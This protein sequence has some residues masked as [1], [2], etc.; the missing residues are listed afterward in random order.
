MST[1]YDLCDVKCFSKYLENK[2]WKKQKQ[3]WKENNKKYTGKEF[4]KIFKGVCVANIGAGHTV[5]IKDGNVLDI[6]DSTEG[7]IGNYWIKEE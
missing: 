2:G 1:G 5:C 3:P 4:V 6:W 7:C